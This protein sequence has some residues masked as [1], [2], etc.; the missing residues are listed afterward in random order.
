MFC[1]FVVSDGWDWFISLKKSGFFSKC[2][3]FLLEKKH[4]NG[5]IGDGKEGLKGLKGLER[6]GVKE[7]TSNKQ[8]N[9]HKTKTKTKKLQ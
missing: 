6:M 1:C 3:V 7:A 9:L 5:I 8:Q 2:F 4:R